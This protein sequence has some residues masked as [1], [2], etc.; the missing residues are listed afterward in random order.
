MAYNVNFIRGL[1]IQ[2]PRV[3][4]NKK[5]EIAPLLNGKGFIINY[6]HHSI[7]MNK[8]RKFAFYSLQY[9]RKRVEEYEPEGEF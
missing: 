5:N 9:Q 7:V 1:P 3:A 6:L 4:K 2:L 8:K